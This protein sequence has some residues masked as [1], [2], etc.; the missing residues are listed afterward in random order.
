MRRL[1]TFWLTIGLI[2]VLNQALEAGDSTS[3]SVRDS[4]GFSLP[5]ANRAKT[6]DH[7]NRAGTADTARRILG[8]RPVAPGSRPALGTVC[9]AGRSSC[10]Q[11]VSLSPGT[12]SVRCG[13][14]P[15]EGGYTYSVT[16]VITSSGAGTDWAG[17]PRPLI[18]RRGVSNRYLIWVTRIG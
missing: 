9:G 5:S 12:Y 18:G 16:V 8:Q 14:H 10:G 11:R 17:C 15:H 7:A 1:F 4:V 6:A 3:L 2:L 13:S